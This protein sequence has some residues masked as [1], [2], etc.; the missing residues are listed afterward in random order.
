MELV[1][2]PI[3]QRNVLSS[4][5]FDW[6]V[7]MQL[8]SRRMEMNSHSLF[9]H[10]I[11]GHGAL[12]GEER[13]K[14]DSDHTDKLNFNYIRISAFWVKVGLCV[15]VWIT[16]SP[17]LI[18]ICITIMAE[19]IST[20]LYRRRSGRVLGKGPKSF[21]SFWAWGKQL[22][23]C[24]ASE[25]KVWDCVRRPIVCFLIE[26]WNESSR[27]RG[28]RQSVRFLLPTSY[29]WEPKRLS[30]IDSMSMSVG[31]LYHPQIYKIFLP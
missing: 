10:G 19:C 8:H 5:L 1:F 11:H 28:Y 6:Q 21:K 9:I 27:I 4:L 29:T 2:T 13:G 16:I 20:A 17:P 7:E 12:P 14:Q 18:I 31:R 23:K 22:F 30:M 25:E 15:S 3:P 26:S 24:S